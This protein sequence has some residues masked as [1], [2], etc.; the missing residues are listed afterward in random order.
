MKKAEGVPAKHAA[1]SPL[2]ALSFV[3]CGLRN[4]SAAAPVSRVFFL[5]L[6]P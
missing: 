5:I 2:F 3:I 6:S 1:K 4:A